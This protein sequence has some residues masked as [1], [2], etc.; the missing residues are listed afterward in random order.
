[1]PKNTRNAVCLAGLIVVHDQKVGATLYRDMAGIHTKKLHT[2]FIA[3][4]GCY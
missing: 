1:M 4:I 2:S 3:I